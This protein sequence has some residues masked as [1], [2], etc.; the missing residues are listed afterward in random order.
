[1]KKTFFLIVVTF[2]LFASSVYSQQSKDGWAFGFGAVSPRLF[3]DVVAENL[4]FGGQILIQKNLS[5]QV[6][7]R[8]SADYLMFTA[9]PSKFTN[10]TLKVGAAAIYNLFPCQSM[11][12]YIGLGG[13]VLYSTLTNSVNV[14]NKSYLG[15]ISTDIYFGSLFNIGEDW[16]LKAE[17]GAHT[18]T[19]DKF[20]GTVAGGGAGGLFGGSLD[21]YISVNVGLLYYFDPGT[22][23]TMCDMQD[24]LVVDY[25]RIEDMIKKYASKPTDV[26]YNKIED[27]VKK[28]KS[29][30]MADKADKNWVLIGVNFDFNKST[31]SPESYPIL[32]DAAGVLLLNP[33]LKV[34]IQGH[35]DN[36]GSASSNNKLSVARAES[37][38]GYLMAKGVEASRLST[39]GFGDTKPISDN[40]TAQG[41][42]FN[43]RI[44]FK[45]K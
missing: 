31:L 15:E 12:P 5:E 36:I 18:L 30:Q 27:I 3:S 10:N 43:R 25:N 41:R 39:T 7:L 38:K 24:G 34:E 20:D 35:T 22:K 28:H 2:F 23:S 16:L 45:V 21:A 13:S 19:T 8:L 26:D 17:F 6:G 40:K 1:M 14:Q 4:D 29:V 44:E 37:V 32:A 33:E 9:H 42:T 11:S